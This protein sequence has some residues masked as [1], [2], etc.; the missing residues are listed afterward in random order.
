MT[1]GTIGNQLVSWSYGG[2]E[3]HQL[4]HSSSLV[5]EVI[6]LMFSTKDNPNCSAVHCRGLYITSTKYITIYYY[7]LCTADGRSPYFSVTTLCPLKKD[8]QKKFTALCLFTTRMPY[9]LYLEGICLLALGLFMFLRKDC[10]FHSTS[11]EEVSSVKMFWTTRQQT[12]R[13][14][15]LTKTVFFSL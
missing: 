3:E 9:K 2:Q 6:P 4:L 7:F 1:K 13:F 15:Y 12:D 10:L 11:M 8:E 14:S 5:L